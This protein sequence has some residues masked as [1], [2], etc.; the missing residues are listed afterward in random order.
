MNSITTAMAAANAGKA[1]SLRNKYRM[2][3]KLITDGL[4]EEGAGL[5]RIAILVAAIG[6]LLT[7]PASGLLGLDDD[8]RWRWS[9]SCISQRVLTARSRLR[10][11]S[12]RT[13]RIHF[14]SFSLPTTSMCHACRMNA[15]KGS[16]A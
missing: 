11:G 10:D 2:N 13:R 16:R 5:S 14:S 15:F 9:V 12:R 3:A 8:K 1:N 4:S 7:V 6:G